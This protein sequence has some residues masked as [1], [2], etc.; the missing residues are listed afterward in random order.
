MEILT[1][2]LSLDEDFRSADQKPNRPLSAPAGNSP[3]G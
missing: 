1:L 2:S 3:A